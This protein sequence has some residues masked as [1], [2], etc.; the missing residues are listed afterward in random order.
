MPFTFRILRKKKN[1]KKLLM[2]F[3]IGDCCKIRTSDGYNTAISDG[4][5]YSTTRL[6]VSTIRGVFT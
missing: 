5:P 2:R 1:N 6:R 3:P 4:G